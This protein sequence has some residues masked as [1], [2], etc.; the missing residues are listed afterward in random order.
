MELA[1]TRREKRR[2]PEKDPRIQNPSSSLPSVGEKMATSSGS[3]EEKGIMHWYV[4]SL[5]L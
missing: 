5:G 4:E 1:D 2:I 3:K